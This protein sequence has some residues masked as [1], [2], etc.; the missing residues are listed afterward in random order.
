MADFDVYMGCVWT[1][2][3]NGNVL[4]LQR[5]L[6][7]SS[8]K[9]EESCDG[10]NTA[11]LV[12]E[13]P[14]F[15]YIEDN[16]FIEE[17]TID[18]FLAWHTD[19]HTVSFSG[20]ISAIDIDFP[21]EGTPQL[22]VFCL[23]GSHLMNRSKK[24]RSWDKVTNADVV[25]KIAAEYGFKTKIEDGYT[26]T[27]EDTISQSNQSDIEFLESLANKEK[28]PFMAKL[29]GDTIHYVKLGVLSDPVGTLS[30]RTGTFDIVSF[31]PQINKETNEEEVNVADVT[32]STKVTDSAT[33][34]TDN[35][36]TET[37]GQS[38]VTSSSPTGADAPKLVY[39]SKTDTWK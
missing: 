26:F 36:K 32:A 34:T 27:T 19:T 21:G 11:T 39:D 10:S 16:I 14:D 31:N 1:I 2:L 29:V 18:I 8:F 12:V 23:D 20:Y 4:D 3:I 6:C 7:I 13:D 22:S 24:K 9:I 5:R 33:A 17:A 38:V 28:T 25:K 37:Q 15:L 35:T 30:Y